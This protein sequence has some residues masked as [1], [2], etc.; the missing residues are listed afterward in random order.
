MI[1]RKGRRR[2]C[3]ISTSFWRHAGDHFSNERAKELKRNERKWTKTLMDAGWTVL[4]SVILDRQRALGLSSTDICILMHLA[5]HW[6]FQENL[7]HPSKRTIARCMSVSESTIQRRIREMERDGI[8]KRI[9]RFN[10]TT[11]GQMTNAYDFSGL[12]TSATPYAKEAIHERAKKKKETVDRQIR[13][14]V[15]R[16]VS[17]DN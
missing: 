11:K 6:W 3:S 13:K 16:V 7:P 1:S 8:I 14:R 4:P 9:A 17:N 2:R 15:L 10:V 5:K 12:I